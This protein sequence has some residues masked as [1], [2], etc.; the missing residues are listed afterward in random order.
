MDYH[1]LTLLDYSF[2]PTRFLSSTLEKAEH[3]IIAHHFT[4]KLTPLP[5]GLEPNS[6]TLTSNS[7]TISQSNPH[8]TQNQ[9]HQPGIVLTPISSYIDYKNTL[10]LF[11][12]LSAVLQI[13]L[14]KSQSYQEAIS[15]E[16]L[17]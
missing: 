4:P 15:L 11:S 12:L 1:F 17:D 13:D 6:S 9:A 8:L 16:N 10:P 14:I 5:G 7:G 3:P 2:S